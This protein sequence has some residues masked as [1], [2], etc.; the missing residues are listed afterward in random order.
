[1]SFY[2]NPRILLVC[3]GFTWGLLLILFLRLMKKAALKSEVT[4]DEY[5]MLA[6]VKSIDKQDHLMVL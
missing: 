5:S 6:V 2:S 4:V 1:M 3:R